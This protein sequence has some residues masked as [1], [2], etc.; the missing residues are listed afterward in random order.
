[1][2]AS[3][4]STFS[5]LLGALVGGGISYVL[6]RQQF[7]NQLKLAIEHIADAAAHEGAEQR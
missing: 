4:W 3:L 1:M 7:A 5:A 6:N 2:E